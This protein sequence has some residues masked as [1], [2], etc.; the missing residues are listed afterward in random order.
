MKLYL[1]L[2]LPICVAQGSFYS[3]NCSSKF[4]E[5]VQPSAAD[6]INLVLVMVY[7]YPSKPSSIGHR[8]GCGKDGY[9]LPSNGSC[10]NLAE[11]KKHYR[12]VRATI[13]DQNKVAKQVANAI[14]QI[15]VIAYDITDEGDCPV[16]FG[17]SIK[18]VP[19]F[20][21]Y[22]GGKPYICDSKIPTLSCDV[23]ELQFV[24]A[25]DIIDFVKKYF[26]ADIEQMN[27]QAN[28]DLR[29]RA[30]ILAS[31]PV[32]Y[33]GIYPFFYGGPWEPWPWFY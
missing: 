8:A 27:I 2:L 16:D 31:R 3:V 6:P 13:K 28:K 32:L 33:S 30:E 9:C 1:M 12:D 25:Q 7:R 23:S 10:E 19:T 24:C 26:G 29:R 17:V 15:D 20:I 14:P 21:L 4:L 18:T 5:L 11:L 22:R